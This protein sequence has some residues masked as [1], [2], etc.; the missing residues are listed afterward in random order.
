MHN[1]NNSF[2]IVGLKAVSSHKLTLYVNRE[3]NFFIFRHLYDI[4]VFG[5][6]MFSFS[7]Q[8]NEII[9]ENIDNFDLKKTFECGQCFRW[10]ENGEGVW[11]SVVAGKEISIKNDGE[12]LILYPCNEN[13]FNTFWRNYFDLD[14]DYSKI[15]DLLCQDEILSKAVAYGNGIRILNQDPWET[16][17]S[18][19]ISQNNNIPRIKGIVERL[20]ENFGEKI[21]TNYS[22]PSAKTIAKLNIDDLNI[23]RCGF[24]AKYIIDAAKKVTDGS[25]NFD[26]LKLLNENTAREQLMA[27][28]GVGEKVADCT[29]LFGLSHI[30]V[31]PKD[32]WIK[33]ALQVFY[34][35][36]FPEC[37]LSFQGIA[38]QYLFYF[39]R[40]TKLEI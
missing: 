4:I 8:N 21:G 26:E 36:N 15:N 19:I 9:I 39:A 38:Q 6:Y 11:K 14:R 7:C 16:L 3:L 17:C 27:I 40:E 23:I 10:N 18:F 33:R 35:G 30:N 34:D 37:A 22:F 32:V 29:L 12:R 2:K 5:D 25:I 28:Y 31:C 1:F 24:R 20:C 13:D